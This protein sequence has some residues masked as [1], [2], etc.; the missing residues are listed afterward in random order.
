MSLMMEGRRANGR[1]AMASLGLASPMEA[2]REAG[3]RPD[4][5]RGGGEPTPSCTPSSYRRGL[6]PAHAAAVEGVLFRVKQGRQ[7]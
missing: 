4:E 5:G 2:N 3:E 6:E 1:L 7:E